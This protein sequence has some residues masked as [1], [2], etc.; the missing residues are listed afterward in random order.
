ML[1]V[2]WIRDRC[3]AAD[4][5]FQEVTHRGPYFAH[6][7]EAVIREVLSEH[8]AFIHGDE[9]D[10][11]ERIANRLRE[12]YAFPRYDPIQHRV[13]TRRKYPVGRCARCGGRDRQLPYLKHSKR[14][15]TS[16]LK[17]ECW[18]CRKKRL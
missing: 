13:P 12:L 3:S 15:Q 2:S 6:D 1:L 9:I 18:S 5:G 11:S 4:T 10:V 14:S 16:R 7:L 8:A 17:R